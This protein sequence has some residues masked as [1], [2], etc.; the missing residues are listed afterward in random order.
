MSMSFL[1]I[2]ASPWRL[3][4]QSMA[5]KASSWKVMQFLPGSPGMLA[6]RMLLS[7]PSSNPC[8][9]AMCRCCGRPPKLSPVVMVSIASPRRCLTSQPPI[10]VSV[11]VFGNWV[12]ADNPVKMWSVMWALI[13]YDWCSYKKEEFGHGDRHV[14]KTP[15]KYECGDQHDISTGQGTP[16]IASNL[17]KDWRESWNR[18]SL[19]VLRRNEPCHPA[20]TLIL[21][22]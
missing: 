20:D 9:Q 14:S 12:F 22:L 16:K 13:Q 10:L 11:I 15:C 5:S 1:W 2:W 21:A 8:G 7:E 3:L 6:S 17:P 4:L 19:I 18:F